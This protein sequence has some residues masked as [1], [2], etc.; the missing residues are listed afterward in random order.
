VRWNDD[1]N[2]KVVGRH[3]ET[4]R[5][6]PE[7]IRWLRNWGIDV[8]PEFRL[9]GPVLARARTLR[10]PNARD[11]R[12]IDDFILGL[13]V[14]ALRES[15]EGIVVRREGIAQFL[16]VPDH[17]VSLSLERLNKLGVLAQEH[18][19]PPA[20]SDRH[21]REGDD[22]SAWQGST[23]EVRWDRL[24]GLLETRGLAR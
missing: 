23:R 5:R 21:A 24:R 9:A 6:S 17:A 20:G 4:I 19:A 11:P 12:R 14:L 10:R 7:S 13:L 2:R 8:E 1:K 18:N 15:G 22:N 16:G 3:A